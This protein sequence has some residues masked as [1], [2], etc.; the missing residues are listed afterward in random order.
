[1]GSD[2]DKKDAK[3]PSDNT[4]TVDAATPA[5]PEM[6]TQST[7]SGPDATTS[8]PATSA[9]PTQPDTSSALSDTEKVR[10][11]VA[12]GCPVPDATPGKERPY[13][14]PDQD[15][16]AKSESPAAG[17]GTATAAT[18]AASAPTQPDASAPPVTPKA[19]NDSAEQL[20]DISEL[21]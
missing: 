4:K 20:Y 15:E 2:K 3:A 12:M 14:A 1:M 5:A 18:P 11:I 16:P 17:S 6:T 21:R 9:A 13:Q 7:A 10:Q 19:P 8:V